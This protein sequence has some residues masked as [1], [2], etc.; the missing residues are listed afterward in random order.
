MRRQQIFSPMKLNV[1][2]PT[3]NRSQS[4]KKTLLS[5]LEAKLPPDLDIVVTVVNNNS[6]D[7]TQQILD[8][9]QPK[10]VDRRLE[11]LFEKKQGQSFALN[12]GIRHAEGELLT[13]VDDDIQIE[14]N[15]FIE[16]EKIF[17]TRWDEIDFAGGKILPIW[18]DEHIPDWIGP[19]KDG[20][21]GWR[22]YGEEEWVYGRDTPMLTG[23]HAVFKREVFDQ[24]GFFPEDVGPIG[25][26]F[27]SCGDDI[28]YD[29][30][31]SAEKRGIYFPDL[32][33][34]H[35]V[36]QYRVS[37]SYYRQWCFGAGMSWNLMDAKYKSFDGVR[38]FGVPRYMYRQTAADM[39]G[40]I[41]AVFTRNESESLARENMIFV[42]AGFFYARNL[43]DSLLD[44]PLRSVAKRFVK[45]VER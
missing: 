26:N 33:V 36:P 37:K 29:R 24:I 23:G 42:F 11:Q 14:N 20:V 45:T 31:L 25:K 28:I 30:L 22:E 39:A 21:I 4:L 16:I 15:W 19:L 35:F 40:K 38:I 1:I 6:S 17:R 32:V 27:L 44:R 10:F 41:K 2:V 12:A 5:L 9:M 8:E 43:R 7:D 13:T 34:F 3:Y 18:E